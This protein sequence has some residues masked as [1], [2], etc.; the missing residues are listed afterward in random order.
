MDG[1]FRGAVRTTR[2]RQSSLQVVFQG[3]SITVV[4]VRAPDGG[5]A[6]VSIDGGV[7]QTSIDFKAIDGQRHTG[8]TVFSSGELNSSTPHTL[9][10]WYDA[11]SI[12][13]KAPHGVIRVDSFVISFPDTQGSP[14]PN[15]L[16]PAAPPG[17]A[18]T[19]PR[20]SSNAGSP[21]FT[22][23]TGPTSESTSSPSTPAVVGTRSSR[24]SA[25]PIVAG[26]VT[27]LGTLLVAGG[28]LF[29][30]FRRRRA[31]PVQSM[32]P[33]RTSMPAN[34]AGGARSPPGAGARRSAPRAPRGGLL[35]L[36]TYAFTRRGS[37]VTSSSDPPVTQTAAAPP[38]SVPRLTPF[39][40]PYTYRPAYNYPFSEDSTS[41]GP[42]VDERP[43]N[44]PQPPLAS[45][46][47][48]SRTSPPRRLQVFNPDANTVVSSE[49][50]SGSAGGR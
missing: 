26:L 45:P 16:P 30:L 42:P 18:P 49:S 20:T 43:P 11:S 39:V 24:S 13:R 7:P 27:G 8:E 23:P 21:Y 34:P 37:S 36:A 29:W 31:V 41:L 40:N 22:Q 4:G 46:I 33:V 6:V 15:D 2:G 3:S 32:T 12:P 25:I 35:S 28:I 5:K 9:N 14:F 17:T 38:P 19:G 44:V 1:A 50:G 48:P 10:L 47:S